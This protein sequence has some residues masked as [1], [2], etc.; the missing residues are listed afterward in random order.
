MDGARQ[1]DFHGWFEGKH[2]Y[3]RHNQGEW[4]AEKQVAG[5]KMS[6]HTQSVDGMWGHLKTW[7]RT[8]RGVHSAYLPGYVDCFEWQAR[9]RKENRFNVFLEGLRDLHQELVA[10][11]GDEA[12]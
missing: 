4:V 7:L 9:T 1:H 10:E 11:D 2:Q 6:V 8:R 12:P 5:K 3:V